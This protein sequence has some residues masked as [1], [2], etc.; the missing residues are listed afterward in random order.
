MNQLASAAVPPG[1]PD[2]HTYARQ[3]K[4]VPEENSADL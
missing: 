4:P 1:K 3:K 2:A